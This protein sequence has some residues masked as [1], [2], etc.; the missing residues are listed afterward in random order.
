[1]LLALDSNNGHFKWTPIY[2][3]EHLQRN[4]LSYLSKGNI[5]S[6]RSVDKNKTRVLYLTHFFR[7][8]YNYQEKQTI[9]RYVPELLQR[10]YIS[11]LPALF[12]NYYTKKR[13]CSKG[14]LLS[15]IRFLNSSK[16]IL[17]QYVIFLCPTFQRLDVFNWYLYKKLSQYWSKEVKF[18]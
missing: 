9:V 15:F 18:V 14:L 4:R 3:C 1:M 12:C 13:C 5:F 7:K 16:K 11:K 8:P 6:S 2:I 17:P 10:V